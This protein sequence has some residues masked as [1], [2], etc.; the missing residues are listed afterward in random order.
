MSN[1]V[2]HGLDSSKQS[3]K[4]H[5]IDAM[6]KYCIDVDYRNLSY[7][8][9]ADFYHEMVETIKPDI[10]VGHSLGGYWR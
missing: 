2:F 1:I 6:H 10:L 5:A 3:T 4:F 7:Q 9:V 8:S